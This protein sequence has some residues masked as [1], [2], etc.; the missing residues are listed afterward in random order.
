MFNLP[1]NELFCCEHL[2]ETKEQKSLIKNF[3]VQ[4]KQCEGL[5]IFLKHR[6]LIEENNS[7]ARTYLV[8]DKE[9]KELVAYFT[10]KAGLMSQNDF[11]IEKPSC[12]DSI[13]G[14][15]IS[16]FAVNY[17][18]KLAHNEYEGLGK[19]VFLLF[20]YAVN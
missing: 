18:Y 14:V 15:E 2:R 6:A 17:N 20:Y 11:S 4:Y 9:T 3:R 12:F 1:E 7:L 13:P 10:L 5:S 8:L 16:N 19:I